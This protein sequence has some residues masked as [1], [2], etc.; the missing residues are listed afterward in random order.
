MEKNKRENN[1]NTLWA[2]FLNNSGYSLVM[3]LSAEVNIDN[4]LNYLNS[5]VLG[6][7]LM[8]D[9][10]IRTMP[11]GEFGFV[12]NINWNKASKK[13]RPED[14]VTI[15]YF[16]AIPKLLSVYSVNQGEGAISSLYENAE[17]I[18]ETLGI[19]FNSY[20]KKDYNPSYEID[21]DSIVREV[22]T[23]YILNKYHK[24]DIEL[25]DK[26][27]SKYK[28]DIIYVYQN[29]VSM[30]AFLSDFNSFIANLI[31]HGENIKGKPNF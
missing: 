29:K 1:L 21:Y 23:T 26:L 19:P 2:E 16:K 30:G 13:Y 20:N 31:D 11:A 4:L 22:I 17:E 10:L 8:S 6:F 27:M 15:K 12:V 14:L 5:P 28:N 24:F 18:A 25:R 3:P 7:K 9:E